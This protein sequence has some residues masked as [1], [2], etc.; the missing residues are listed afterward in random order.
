[1]TQLIASITSIRTDDEGQGLAEYALI[2]SL[3]ALVAVIALIFMGRQVST[4]LQRSASPS[5]NRPSR[6]S[7]SRR[8]ER[9]GGSVDSAAAHHPGPALRRSVSN[10]AV[11]LAASTISCRF[12]L[13]VLALWYSRAAPGRC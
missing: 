11:F 2:L 7:R 3:I 13:M 9:P 4:M 5:R 12:L 8:A 10:L 6:R 1:M